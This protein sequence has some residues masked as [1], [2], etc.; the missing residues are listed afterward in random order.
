VATNI[1]MPALSPTMEEGKLARWLVKEGDTVKSGDILA[2]IE[3]DKAT[4]EFEAVDEGRI[5]KILVPEGSEGVKVNAPIAVLLG[6]DEKPGE[7][8]ISA[9]MKNIGEAVKA[10]APK[11]AETP[12][13]TEQATKVE[14]PKAEAAPTAPKAPSAPSHDGNR[15]FASPLARRIATQKGIDL[16]ALSGTGPRGRIVKSDVEAAKP[17]AKPAAA[18]APKGETAGAGMGVAPLPD[19][20]LFYK[21]GEYEEIPHDSMRKAIAKRLTSAKALIPHYY[22]TIDCNLTAL[23]ATRTALNEAAGKNATYKLSVNDFVVKASA[24]ALMK[25]PD[26]NA[27]WTDTAILRHKHADVGIAVAIPSG[28]ITPIVFAAETKGLA[29]ISNEVKDLATRAKDKKLKPSEYEGGGFSVSNLGMFGIKSFTSI[30]NPPQSCIIAVG[31]G[32]ERA[33]VVNGKVEIATMMTITMSCDHRVVD[34]ATGAKFLQTLK[35]FI[36]EPASMLL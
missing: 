2:E 22:L 36:E 26:V 3:T 11:K 9:A 4:M 27:S 5:G 31:A 10:E 23:M 14:T 35:R 33:I 1:L 16:A 34:G 12:A 6:D 17:G 24:M 29:Q 18:A 20:R 8:D 7:V 32:E 28:L 19:A 21:A 15:I 25:H 30:I 13:K